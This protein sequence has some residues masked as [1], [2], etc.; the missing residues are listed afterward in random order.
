LNS[1]LGLDGNCIVKIQKNNSFLSNVAEDEGGAIIWIKNDY[2]DD[3]T[4]IFSHNL[5]NYGSDVASY[6]KELSIEFLTNN[7]YYEPV[8]NTR[9]L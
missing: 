2:L 1:N 4:N 8:S 3:G 5:A 6:P 9:L 7:D